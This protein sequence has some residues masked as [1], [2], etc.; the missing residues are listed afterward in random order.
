MSNTQM[1]TLDKISV[2]CDCSI[3]SLALSSE[4]KARFSEMGLVFSTIVHIKKKAPLG[5][6]IEIKIRNYTL[7]LR[8]TEAEHIYVM[9]LECEPRQTDETAQ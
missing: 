2:G 9:P 3:V 8:A 4:I 6:P 5:D 1:T 7:C